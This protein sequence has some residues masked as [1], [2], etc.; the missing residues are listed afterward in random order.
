MSVLLAL[1]AAVS[2]AAPPSA[3][4]PIADSSPIVVQGTR[5]PKRLASDYLDK[6]VPP[7]FDA[8]LGRFE[9]PICA[10]V[11][12]LPEQLKSEVLTRIRTVAAATGMRVG[13]PQCAP[14]LLIV[15]M[16]DKKTMIEGMRRHKQAYLYGLGGDRIRQLE[17]AA[18]P[19]VAWQISDVIGADGM[20]LRVDG[21]GFPRLF[22]T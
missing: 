14:N 11:I 1:T 19:A 13:G 18:T 21:D 5:D 2:S 9:E 16:D 8:E 6:V 20:P 4:L 17:N 22:T 7:T 15:I 10:G 3:Q 12:G